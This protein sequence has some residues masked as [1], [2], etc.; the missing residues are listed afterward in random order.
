LIGS[1]ADDRIEGRAGADRI[2]GGAGEDLLLGGKGR[3]SL[4]GG[5]GDDVLVGG[6]GLDELSG[7]TGADDFVIDGRFTADADQLVDFS[8][9]DGDRIVLSHFR[10]SSLEEARERMRVEGGV[11]KFRLTPELDEAR[12]I[13]RLGR[14]DLTLDLLFKRD[15]VLLSFEAR[16]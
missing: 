12:P 14:T 2:N 4:V 7:G 3:D 6:P 15:S 9:E 11:L 1:D 8:P 13:A 16:F 5:P 10:I